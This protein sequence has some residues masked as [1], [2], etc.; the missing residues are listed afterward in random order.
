MIRKKY[1]KS[2]IAKVNSPN[3]SYSNQ[4]SLFPPVYF[5]NQARSSESFP[6]LLFTP[7]NSLNTVTAS[8][9]SLE[10]SAFPE[11]TAKHQQVSMNKPPKSTL[12]VGVNA[13]EFNLNDY[14][15]S[16]CNKEEISTETENKDEYIENWIQLRKD[17]RKDS[18]RDSRKDSRKESRKDSRRNSSEASTPHL[19][20]DYK[21]RL[22]NI[23]LLNVSSSSFSSSFDNENDEYR[24]ISSGS[25]Y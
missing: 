17:R 2:R 20:T 21:Q 16:F 9:L 15:K 1:I 4:E 23:L 6:S 5:K 19:Y 3:V 18:R 14:Q 13:S 8:T 11:D 24:S 7:Q 12:H 10:N 25:I 22:H